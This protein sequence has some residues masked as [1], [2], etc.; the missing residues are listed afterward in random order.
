[1]LKK[2]GIPCWCWSQCWLSGAFHGQ[3]RSAIRR[4]GGSGLPLSGLSLRL[5]V[6]LWLR[7]YA[8]Y[9]APAYQYYWRG[10]RDHYYYGIIAAT[11]TGTDIVARF[12]RADQ[13]LMPGRFGAAAFWLFSD[14]QCPDVPEQRRILELNGSAP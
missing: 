12:R 9:P 2:I 8:P 13:H 11:N 6:P 14:G 5:L 10:H 3:R 4:D 1:M 7:Y